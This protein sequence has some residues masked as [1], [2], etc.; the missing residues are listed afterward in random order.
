VR[1]VVTPKPAPLGADATLAAVTEFG[2][3]HSLV[4]AA[5]ARSPS[6]PYGFY[7]RGFSQT[8][9]SAA[10][11]FKRVSTLGCGH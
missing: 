2:Q 8:T 7:G 6:R 4:S 11:Q 5:P 3:A 1:L 9:K 10:A